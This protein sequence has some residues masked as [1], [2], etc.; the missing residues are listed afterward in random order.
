MNKDIYYSLIEQQK[1]D[2]DYEKYL[3]TD[4]L[5]SAQK[6]LAD[7]LPDELQFQIV[8]QSEELLMKLLAY[9]LIDI[10]EYIAQKNTPRV[11]TLFRR[12]H[13]IQKILI[14]QLS[15]LETMSPKEYFPIRS[16]LG[17]GSGQESPGFNV[18][19][20]VAA[21]VWEEFKKHYVYEKNIS[22]EKIYD[23]EYCHSEE[24]LLAE[25]FLEYDALFQQ[26][27]YAHLRLVERTIG[28]RSTSLK[29]RSTDALSISASR[30]LFPELWTVRTQ[31]TEIWT[32]KHKDNE[33]KGT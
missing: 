33:Y 24:Y 18:L 7:L 14:N 15:L 22:I 31:M 11:M 12:S 26:F 10:G 2:T 20:K 28:P 19:M 29:G 13:K 4:Q 25:Q 17:K 6:K 1:G 3:Q 8:H 16:L 21:P 23:D 9:T 30:N 32:Q 27:L 5:L